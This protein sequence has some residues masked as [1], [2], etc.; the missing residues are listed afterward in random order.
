[1]EISVKAGA[2]I[3]ENGGETYR[4]EETS[5]Y[6]AKALGAKNPSAFVTPTV[7]IVSATDLEGKQYTYMRRITSR[8]VNLQKI[9]QI[10]S[11]SRRLSCRKKKTG[12]PQA[13][14]LLSKISNAPGH[15]MPL[16]AFMAGLSAVFFTLM[17]GGGLVEALVGFV[18][19]V[20]L[21][22]I[23]VFFE[24]LHLN[25]FIVSVICGAIISMLCEI[26]LV[27][28]IVPSSVT[29]MT[30]VLMQVVPGMSIVNAIRDLIAGDLMAGTARLVDA[31]MVA[32]GLSSG[33]AF[34]L[35]VVSYAFI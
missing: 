25:S 12:V 28:G 5:V 2:M 6:I 34:G 29:V 22:L 13:Q 23:L 17:F 10:N 30:A 33:S 4:A 7:V 3:L 8:T 21:R 32:A 14:R 19:G 11:L 18:I 27:F 26:A 24:K 9:A 20:L 31:F 15:K 1:M 16:V 35:L